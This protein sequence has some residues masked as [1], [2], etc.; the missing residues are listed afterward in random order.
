MS[1]KETSRIKEMNKNKLKKYY[2]DFI[3]FLKNRYEYKVKDELFS[4]CT[5][6]EKEDGVCSSCG[7]DLRCGDKK[8]IHPDQYKNCDHPFKFETPEGLACFDCDLQFN[9]VYSKCEHCRKKRFMGYSDF[10]CCADCEFHFV[11]G[12]PKYINPKQY[13]D[14]SHS[15][16]E[17]V[18]GRV[19]CSRCRF[20]EEKEVREKIISNKCVHRRFEEEYNGSVFLS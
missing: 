19:V 7:Y 15:H 10:Y 14:C 4:N 12:D 3:Q 1:K 2:E 17:K 8:Y 5:H 20:S 18:Y 9:I 13:E 16:M 6:T 11:D